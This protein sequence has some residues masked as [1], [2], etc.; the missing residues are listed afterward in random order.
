MQ[1]LHITQASKT[2]KL[3]S[4]NSINTSVLNNQFCDK[5]RKGNDVLKRTELSI[6]CEA[7][8]AA[9]LEKQYTNLHKAITR[10]DSLLSDAPLEKRQLPVIMDRVLRFHS[11][12]ELINIQ[13]LENFCTIANY[14]PETFFTLWTK[15]TDL[16]NKYFSENDKPLNL[17]LIYSSPRVGKIESLPLHFDK[18]FTVHAKKPSNENIDINCHSKCKD[19]M[20]CYKKNDVI[21]I[22]EIIK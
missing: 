12:G 9:T 1:T 17:S 8:Y 7:C 4:I 15:R 2:G 14:N 3:E 6:V 5:M 22:N 19:C 11:L 21:Y 18:V 16:I 10:N 13:H 20:L